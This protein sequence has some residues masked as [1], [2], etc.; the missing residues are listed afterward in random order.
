MSAADTTL[1]TRQREMLLQKLDE[2]ERTNKAL[3]RLLREQQAT[4]VLQ[5]NLILYN[6]R[7]GFSSHR[8][9]CI[10]R[11]LFSVCWLFFH[12]PFGY[13]A[14]AG[15]FMIV[16]KW[17]SLPLFTLF[18]P[19]F[20]SFR[21]RAV[22]SSSSPGTGQVKPGFSDWRI[23]SGRKPSLQNTDRNP[24]VRERNFFVAYHFLKPSSGWKFLWISLQQ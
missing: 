7:W 6:S 3:R 18:S 24:L 23:N 14:V 9:C 2:F 4:E 11:L 15:F 10:L 16:A 17:S 8:R 12:L 20:C 5:G 22:C 13:E 1:L 21:L 19:F